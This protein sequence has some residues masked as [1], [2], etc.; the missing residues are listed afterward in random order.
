MAPAIYRD[1]Y[2]AA[3]DLW[4]ATATGALFRALAE[5]SG[6]GPVLC[7]RASEI[8]EKGMFP[9]DSKRTGIVRIQIL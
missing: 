6:S 3:R 5:D 4:S 7:H 8:M 9:K 2:E 1:D